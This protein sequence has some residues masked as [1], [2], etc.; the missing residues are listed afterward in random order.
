MVLTS[1]LTLSDSGRGVAAVADVAAVAVLRAV[2]ACVV[3][4]SSSKILIHRSTVNH[5]FNQV[6]NFLCVLLLCLI[7]TRA[8]FFCILIAVNSRWVCIGLARH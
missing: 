7:L 6:V 4:G 2:A 8:A 3:V 5:D 1:D